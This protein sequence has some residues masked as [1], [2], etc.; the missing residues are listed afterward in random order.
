MNRHQI[1]Y[2]FGKELV[3]VVF[4]CDNLKFLPVLD[5]ATIGLTVNRK[6]LRNQYDSIFLTSTLDFKEKQNYW[7]L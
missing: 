2:E 1:T 3:L 4:V 6:W 5:Q 7:V